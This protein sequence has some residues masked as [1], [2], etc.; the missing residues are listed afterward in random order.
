MGDTDED[1]DANSRDVETETVCDHLCLVSV[2]VLDLETR[3][4]S[5]SVAGSL[6]VSIAVGV[7][8]CRR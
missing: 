1:K 6:G 8:V 4:A 2:K 5:D 3:G 7:I